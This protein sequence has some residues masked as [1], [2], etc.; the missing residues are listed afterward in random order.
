[1]FLTTK[2][3]ILASTGFYFDLI[4]DVWSKFVRSELK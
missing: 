3:I 2:A 1:M 4:H